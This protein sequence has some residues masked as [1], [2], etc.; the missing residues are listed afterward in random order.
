MNQFAVFHSIESAYS[1]ALTKNR[2]VLRIRVDKNDDISHCYLIYN[3]KHTFFLKRKEKELTRKYEDDLYAYYEIEL[4]LKQSSIAYIFHFVSEVKDYYYSSDGL[5]EAYQR[6]T[7]Y[8][9]FFQMAFINETD[10]QKE[11]SWSKEAIIYEIFVDR[12][13]RSKS[14]GKGDYINLRWG[15]IPNPKSFAGG[16]L[17]GIDEKLRYLKQMGVNTIYLT[18]IF[19]SDSNHKY[20]TRDYYQVDEQFGSLVAFEKLVNDIHKLN[21]RIILD[22]VFNHI[23]SESDIFQDVLKNGKKSKYYDWFIIYDEDLSKENYEKFA[24]LSYMPRLNSSN[25]EVQ[26]YIC[27]IGKYYV[28]KYHIDGWRLD[29]SDEVSHQ[30]WKRFRRE[31]KAIND[32]VLLI[33]ENWQDASPY[34]EGDEFDGIMN[35]SFTRYVNDFL[36]FDKYDAKQLAFNLEKLRMR[37]KRQVVNMNWNLLD[38][39]DTYRLFTQVD[40][41]KDRAIIGCAIQMFYQGIP[42]LYYGDELPLEGGYDP[43]CRRC[44]DF[45]LATKK[46][47]FYSLY[48]EL[49]RLRSSEEAMKYGELTIRVEDGMLVMLRTYRKK[50]I[51]LTINMTGEKKTVNPINLLCYN[52]YDDH[53][54]YDEGFVV[55][56][57]CEN[58]R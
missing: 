55:D 20:D 51:R 10:I 24:S 44:M 36:A 58:R 30:L 6:A 29:V 15:D 23:S 47:W 26:D 14:D 16:T 22:G 1:F 28:E 32:D 18:P 43:D 31:I 41:N 17:N 52:E 46:N 42:C 11:V 45:S 13:Y 40:K 21:M 5:K 2:I 35:Y 34:L 57:Y 38:S 19:K 8:Y 33:G 25:K 53:T 39:H 7:S 56:Y 12:F 4:L 49:V 50:T 3:N 9:N 48:V 54:L 27:G 37:Y